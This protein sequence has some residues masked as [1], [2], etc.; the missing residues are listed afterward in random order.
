MPTIDEAYKEAYASAKPYGVMAMDLRILLM[1]DEGLHE[2]IDVLFYK[3]REMKNYD[4]FKEQVQKL[5]KGEPVEYILGEADFLGNPIKINE[6]VLIPRSE[7]E[8]LVSGISERIDNYYD[9]RNYLVC[10]DIGTGSG[11]ISIGL[12]QSFSNWLLVASDISPKAL[13]VAKE[14]FERYNIRAQVL[15]G[16]ALAPYIE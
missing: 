1:H 7:T 16:D 11:C 4:L 10:A 14:N 15:E 12:R 2:Q 5:I 8:E 9:P 6:N 13:E 3:E